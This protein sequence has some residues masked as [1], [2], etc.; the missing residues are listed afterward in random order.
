LEEYRLFRLALPAAIV[1]ACLSAPASAQ[2]WASKMFA[3]KKHDFGTVARGAKVEH[4]FEFENKYKEDVHISGVRSSCGCTTPKVSQDTVK[5]HE[6]AAIIATFNTRAFL[7]QRTAT[8]TVTFDRPFY[9]E[10]QLHIDGYI[11]SDVVLDPGLVDLGSVEAGVESEK[12]IHVSYAGRDNWEISEVRSAVPYL[13]AAV[14]ETSRGNGQVGY[15][16]IVRLT[17]DAPAGYVKNQLLLITNDRRSTEVPVDVEGRVET[18]MQISPAS[19]FLG[20]LKPGQK[21]TKQIVVRA[22]KPFKILKVHTDDEGFELGT[23]DEAKPLHLIPVT[24]VAGNKSGKF[25]YKIQI[26]TDLGGGTS[27]E[28]PVFAQV[29]DASAETARVD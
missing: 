29:L 8:L 5:T 1:V 13:Q 12:T 26:E 20:V 9:A 11:R 19:L 27:S 23:S 15:D 24:F 22:K 25:T 18:E 4:R 16:L 17:K 10:V 2:D 21:V 6:K 14:K 3:E 28:C 7:G